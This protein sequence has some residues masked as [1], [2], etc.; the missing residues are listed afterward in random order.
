M[1]ESGTSLHIITPASWKETPNCTTTSRSE[2]GQN[3]SG[4]QSEGRAKV[5]ARDKGGLDQGG[6][7]GDREVGGPKRYS[8]REGGIRGHTQVLDPSQPRKGVWV[9]VP[10]TET[11]LPARQTPTALTTVTEEGPQSSA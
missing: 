8:G 2:V 6:G 11:R 5:Q 9:K 7:G 3:G 10:S 4:D 1:Q